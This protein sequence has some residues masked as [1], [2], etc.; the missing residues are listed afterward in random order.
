MGTSNGFLDTLITATDHP[1]A[2]GDKG[3]GYYNVYNN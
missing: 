3:K 1:H 2:Y